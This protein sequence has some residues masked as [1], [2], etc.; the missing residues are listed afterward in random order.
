MNR[1]T[2][3]REP[4]GRRPI[5]AAR[6][7]T[8]INRSAPLAATRNDIVGVGFRGILGIVMAGMACHGDTE[9]EDRAADD[10]GH[11]DGPGRRGDGVSNSRATAAPLR[12]AAAAK[13]QNATQTAVEKHFWA[14]KTV[15]PASA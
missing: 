4:L 5:R 8:D 9:R 10:G 15:V 7:T 2:L 1:P 12:P 11:A 6:C 13:P 3:E 14:S